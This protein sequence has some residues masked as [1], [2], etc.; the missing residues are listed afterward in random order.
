MEMTVG[1]L[2]L[3]EALPEDLRDSSRVIDKKGLKNLMTQVAERYPDKYSEINQKLHNIAT[4]I[5]TTHGRETS[6]SLSNLKPPEG[7]KKLRDELQGKINNILTK[8]ID[9]TA[10]D[11]EIVSTVVPYVDPVEKANFEEHFKN[12]NSLAV[13]VHSGSRGNKAQFRSMTAGDLMVADHKDQPIPIPILS[14]YAE[15]LDPVQYWAGSYGARKGSVATKFATPKAGFLGKQMALAAHRLMITEKDCGTVNGMPVSAS[16]PENEGAVL[17]FPAGGLAAGTILTPKHLQTLGDKKIVVR[18]PI[19]CQSSHGVCQKCVGIHERNGFSPIGDNPGIAAAQAISE[20][21]GQGQ[22]GTKHGGGLVSG[23]KKQTKQGL[24]LITQLV[25]VPKTFAGAAAISQVEGRVERIEPAPQGGNY[26]Y[27]GNTQH[28]APA[29]E[30]IHVKKGDEVEAGDIMSTGIPNPADIVRHKGIGEGRRYFT[31]YLHK[32]LKE[33]GL[34]AHRRN[35]EL[36]SRGLINHVQVTDIDGPHDTVPDDVV[37]YD[38]LV[39]DYKP[40]FGHKTLEPKQ[41]RGLYLEQPALHYSIGT[42]ITPSVIKTLDEHKFGTVKA[43]VDPPSFQPEMQRAMETL[44][45]A[46][47]WM[48]RLGGWQSKKG[49]LESTHRG[50][51]SNVHG[52]SYIPALAQGTE[53]GKPPDGVGY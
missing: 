42:K 21:I 45:H 5:I 28:W 20:P 8:P 25:Q 11:K 24:D 17:A 23:V 22:L 1:Q 13:Q 52:T 53:F 16:D 39:R 15:G 49:L 6:F 51:D 41:A 38:N 26:I 30:N 43:H 34:A 27:V 31:D 14:S 10:K 50:R 4:K 48:V 2:M 32:T 44:S 35:V 7:V 3:N 12:N 19:S 47:D 29:D 9:Q 36:L 18:S 37:E 46:D 40:R 33:S